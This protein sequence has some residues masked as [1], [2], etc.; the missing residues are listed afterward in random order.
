MPRVLE[1][2]QDV[3]YVQ[4]LREPLDLRS[5]PGGTLNRCIG[6]L[7][8]P[9]PIPETDYLLVVN[10]ETDDAY[11]CKLGNVVAFAGPCVFDEHRFNP[12]AVSLT[13][14]CCS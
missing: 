4:P 6:T 8:P 7:V 11:P 13:N 14:S 5:R 10:G 2:W 12:R 3:V 1:T 9:D